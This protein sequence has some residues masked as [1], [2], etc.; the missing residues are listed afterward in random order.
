VDDVWYDCPAGGQITVEGYGGHIQ[1]PDQRALTSVCA[2][3]AIDSS[4][5][6]VSS[7]S[8]RVGG[9]GTKVTIFG[10]GFSNV[11]R[12]VIHAECQQI[13]VVE[14]GIV[15]VTVPHSIHFASP[16]HL[17]RSSVDVM[18]LDE[19][20]RMGVGRSMF[21]VKV[22]LDLEWISWFLSWIAHHWPQVL[23]AL[24]AV[25]VFYLLQKRKLWFLVMAKRSGG[26]I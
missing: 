8:P 9:P 26:D 10:S 25:G 6:V 19:K 20:G 2:G 23:C 4:W 15:V 16:A 7:V 11:T 17:V 24:I 3:N 22:D 18:V 12:V 21:D 13:E 14:E 5:P 1:C